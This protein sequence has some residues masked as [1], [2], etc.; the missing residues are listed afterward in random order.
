VTRQD[1]LGRDLLD[2]DQGSIF[3]VGLTLGLILVLVLYAPVYAVLAGL[4]RLALA[5]G[6]GAR[7]ALR[8]RGSTALLRLRPRGA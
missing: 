4:S 2:H 7:P 5:A 1:M 8:L 3:D 6:E